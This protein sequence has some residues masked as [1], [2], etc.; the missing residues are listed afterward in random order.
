MLIWNKW[1]LRRRDKKTQFTLGGIFDN[2]FLL[3]E[4]ILMIHA[5]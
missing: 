1:V 5:L 3:K 4:E 2:R